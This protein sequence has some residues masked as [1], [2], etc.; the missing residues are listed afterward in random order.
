MFLVLKGKTLGLYQQNYNVSAEQWQA[1]TVSC[2]VSCPQS[3]LNLSSTSPQPPTYNINHTFHNQKNTQKPLLQKSNAV[4]QST[5][6]TLGF[7]SFHPHLD[8]WNFTKL[9]QHDP[10]RPT[11]A[12]SPQGSSTP[13]EVRSDQWWSDQWVN[14]A[15]VTCM[16]LFKWDFFWL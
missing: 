8:P 10:R 14:F 16:L 9:R 12:V 6:S 2:T 1:W 4:N 15:Y 13:W 5:P 11:S 7:G 3:S